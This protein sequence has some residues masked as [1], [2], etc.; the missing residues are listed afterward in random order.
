[1]SRTTVVACYSLGTPYAALAERFWASAISAGVE[2]FSRGFQDRGGWYEN[3][4]QKAVEISLF[5]ERLSG[6]LLYVDVDAEIRSDVAPFFDGIADA[7]YDFGAHFFAG[8]AKGHDRSDVC[9]CVLGEPCSKP[10]RLLSGTLFLGDTEPCRRLLSAWVAR[11]QER[12]AAGHYDG[13]GQKNLWRVFE[14]I[15]GTLRV[16]RLPGRFC[17]VFDK[18]WAYPERERPGE[19]VHSI[20][21]RKYRPQEP[22][23][24]AGAGR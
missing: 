11:N 2:V 10:H 16:A 22:P 3:T 23:K 17:F 12:R 9:A 13:G 5:R 14:E 8:P 19:I 6:P 15:R 21:S 4:A 7:G 20:A 24:P 18:P 1:M